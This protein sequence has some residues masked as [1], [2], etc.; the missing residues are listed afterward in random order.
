M[1][2]RDR[3][4]QA[5]QEIAARIQGRLPDIERRLAGAKENRLKIEAERDAA[6]LAPQRLSD[7]PI[8]SEGGNYHCPRCWVEEGGLS[9]LRHI[10]S[11]ELADLYRCPECE[12]ELLIPH[13]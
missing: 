3:I 9:P 5:A 4:R 11:D 8:Q 1:L 12:Y 10:P 7:F 13:V 2:I 6:R